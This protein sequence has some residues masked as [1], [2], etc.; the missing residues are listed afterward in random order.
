MGGREGCWVSTKR[1]AYYTRLTRS[2]GGGACDYLVLVQVPGTKYPAR[3]FSGVGARVES[4][5][6]RLSL[7]TIHLPSKLQVA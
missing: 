7:N 5:N 3:I 1:R 6:N 2:R 4:T